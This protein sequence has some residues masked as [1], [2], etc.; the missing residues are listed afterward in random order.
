[1]Q[2]KPVSRRSA[3]RIVPPKTLQASLESS[4][5]R[6]VVCDISLGGLAVV[7]ETPFPRNSTHVI[8]LAYRGIVITGGVRTAHCRKCPTGWLVGF[9]FVPVA[10][11]RGPSIEDLID[12]LTGAMLTFPLV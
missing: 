4:R 7:S 6:L 2:D 3:V 11:G 10:R 8:K 5:Q 9:A 1:M 12:D